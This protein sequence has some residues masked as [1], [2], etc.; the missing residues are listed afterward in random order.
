MAIAKAAA[1]HAKTKSRSPL[2][3]TKNPSHNPIAAIQAG[4][5][6]I[7]TNRQHLFMDNAKRRRQPPAACSSF[8]ECT[9]LILIKKTQ[10]TASPLQN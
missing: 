7:P 10:N 9:S 2:P 3:P 6:R 8:R 4:S 5:T 1:T